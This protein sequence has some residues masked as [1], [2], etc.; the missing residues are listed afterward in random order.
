[1]VRRCLNYVKAPSGVVTLLQQLSAEGLP[2]LIV[3]VREASLLLACLSIAPHAAPQ[4]DFNYVL[5]CVRVLQLGPTC[6]ESIEKMRTEYQQRST[7]MHELAVLEQEKERLKPIKKQ[8]PDTQW[9]RYKQL[10]LAKAEIARNP[11]PSYDP[12]SFQGYDQLTFQLISAILQVRSVHCTA[13]HC[14]VDGN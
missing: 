5:L 13:L 3:E 4:T 12:Q 11:A 9:N 7:L 8:M 2:E 1:V 6:L 10:R 14:E